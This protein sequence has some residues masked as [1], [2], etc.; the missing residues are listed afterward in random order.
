MH[1]RLHCRA[2]AKVFWYWAVQVGLGLNQCF[3]KDIFGFGLHYYD[4]DYKSIS[5][6]QPF[7]NVEEL[8]HAALNS[9]DLYN[10][11]IRYMQTAITNPNTYEAMPMLTAYHY[12]QLNRLNESRSYEVGLSNNT[13]NPTTY[14]NSYF[15][16]FTFDAMG[17]I[18]TQKRHERDGGLLD[19]LTYRY[20]MRGTN[21]NALL[22]RNRLYHVNDQVDSLYNE[23]DIDDMA[24][25]YSEHDSINFKNNYS[26][27]AEGRLIRDHQERI[28]QIKWRVDGKV[29]EI[30][31]E[32][33]N[34]GKSNL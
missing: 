12:D 31:R 15:N 7:A 24:V 22:V 18:L 16:A 14:T 27:D 3:A 33:N 21:E 20:Q 25:F 8:S 13:W 4:G 19:D 32:E 17:N 11:N 1:P 34:C 9:H 23:F 10:G 26:Y 2:T 28:A 30:I 6:Q 5:G 29:S